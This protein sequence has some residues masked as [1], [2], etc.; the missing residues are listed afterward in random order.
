MTFVKAAYSN[1]SAFDFSICTS[2]DAGK[3]ST[4]R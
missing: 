1:Q 4:L 3:M 2:N